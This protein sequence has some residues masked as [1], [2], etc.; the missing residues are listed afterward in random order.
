MDYQQSFEN[1]QF[2][3]EN[4]PYS[5]ILVN[6][7]SPLS[8]GYIQSIP[9]YTN[10]VVPQPSLYN[11]NKVQLEPISYANNSYL[12]TLQNTNY[13]YYY[14]QSFI[15]NPTNYLIIPQSQEVSYNS[16]DNGLRTSYPYIIPQYNM[17]PTSA[18]VNSGYV[19]SNINAQYMN[20]PTTSL[21]IPVQLIPNY[22]TSFLFQN[23]FVTNYNNPQLQ[24]VMTYPNNLYLQNQQNMLPYE[25]KS[26]EPE[27]QDSDT[28]NLISNYNFVNKNESVKQ[29]TSQV[30]ENNINTINYNGNINS[31]S[32]GG[33]FYSNTNI[34]PEYQVQTMPIPNQSYQK[35]SLPPMVII[36]K[37]NEDYT[38]IKN[39]RYAQRVKPLTKKRE[40]VVI[41]AYEKHISIKERISIREKGNAYIPTLDNIS[42]IENKVTSEQENNFIPNS[43][44]TYIYGQ[45]NNN[46]TNIENFAISEQNKY[47]I[48]NTDNLVIS[49]QNNNY[50]IPSNE[51]LVISEQNNNYIPNN[52]NID[53]S[54]KD[55]NYTPNNENIAISE[56]EKNYIPNNEN[57]IISEKEINYIPNN[58]NIVINEK[59]NN[60]LSNDEN[61]ANS[62]RNNYIDNNAISG[63]NNIYIPKIEKIIRIEQENNDLPN[64]K[65]NIISEQNN[66]NIQ[67]NENDAIT[68]EENNNLP[69]NDNTILSGED[70][71]YNHTPNKIKEENKVLP[72]RKSFIQ[73][74][75]SFKFPNKKLSQRLDYNSVGVRATSPLYFSGDT[76]ANLAPLSPVRTPI[77]PS[78]EN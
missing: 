2:I 70:N 75:L 23:G 51:N 46:I 61:N 76:A 63:Q 44:N 11:Q 42:N 55:N 65:N 26:Y 22:R 74:P 1:N 50:S 69:T 7:L 77:E 64:I 24:N 20:T 67:K 39:K 4:N 43:E 27:E 6:Q 37:S 41:P 3:G 72:P 17:Q 59:N 13:N 10:A 21:T 8:T 60:Y 19:Y 30:Y 45:D 34:G 9:L 18:I 15:T 56:Q 71:I 5:N 62:E 58:E 53:I 66:N 28:N 36:P 29:M 31:N 40:K 48:R 73:K 12:Y 35:L 32:I 25:T 38:R 33:Y 16:T 68:G 78:K 47:Y 57:N 14:N 54:A 49:E 52:E